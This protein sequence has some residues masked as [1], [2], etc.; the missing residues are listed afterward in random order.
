[1]CLGAIKMVKGKDFTLGPYSCFPKPRTPTV[2][3]AVRTL[4]MCSPTGSWEIL[5]K[6]PTTI[7][8]LLTKADHQL[9][10]CI[11]R[12]TLAALGPDFTERMRRKQ[13]D[14][15]AKRIANRK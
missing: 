15:I 14:A 12:S 1:M 13:L 7:R 11:S 9:Y 6:K 3:W 10:F 8:E 5:L 4:G 2:Q